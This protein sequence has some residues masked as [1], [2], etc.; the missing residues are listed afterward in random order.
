MDGY[1]E[2]DA[3]YFSV[4]NKTAYA[5]YIPKLISELSSQSAN[6]IIETGTFEGLPQ[7][8]V[9]NTKIP[10]LLKQY[11]AAEHQVYNSFM[12]KIKDLNADTQLS[13]FQNYIPK[14]YEAKAASS[15]SI[16]CGTTVFVSSGFLLIASALPFYFKLN[17]N[18]AFMLPWLALIITVTFIISVFIQKKFYLAK[19]NDEH[20]ILAIEALKEVL[21]DE[22]NPSR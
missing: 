10:T 4:A 19:A 11:H 20:L 5:K 22:R 21:K 12:Q 1:S 15:F 7:Y 13:K 8:K 6:K 14:L 16:F 17:N 9:I 18:L 3:V 2:I